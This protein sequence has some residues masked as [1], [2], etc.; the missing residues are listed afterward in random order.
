MHKDWLRASGHYFRL[1]VLKTSSASS[2]SQSHVGNPWLICLATQLFKK[3]L[4][5]LI[6]ASLVSSNVWA[7]DLMDIYHQALDNDPT[8]KAAYAN[9]LAQSEILP[10]A[11]STLLP[12]LSFA[13]LAGRNNQFINAGTY[14]VNQTYNGN[15]WTVDAS[16]A[17]FNYQAWEKV[18]QAESSV[19]A[20][21]ATFNDA[22]Q[23]LIIRTASAY[24]QVLLAQ[25]TLNFAEAKK[26]A[27]KRQLD[28]AQERFNVGLEPI[29]AVY[30]ARAAYD[31][32]IS[33]VISN[34][35]NLTNLNQNL[36][37]ITN[38]VYEH[39]AP[40]RDQRIPLIGPE[41]N[42][43]DEWISAGLKQNYNL[44]AARYNLQSA[45]DNI[46]ANS[47]GNW[48]IFSIQGHVNDVHLASSE[49][50]SGKSNPANATNL[51]NN[52]FI[53]QE[54][55][56]ANLT[57]NVNMPIFQG[58]LVASK[59]RQAEYNFQSSAQKFEQVYRDVVVNSNIYFNT[60]VD[61]I[62]KVRADRQ[63]I[64]S[65]QNSLDSVWAQYK[66]G[67]RTMTDVVLAQQ[68][69]FEA[70]RQQAS[71][72]YDLINAI[73]NLKYYAGSLNVSDLEEINTWLDTLRI[74]SLADNKEHAPCKL[75]A[76]QKLLRKMQ[77]LAIPTTS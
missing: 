30:E 63:T 23:S 77:N 6:C 32:S 34:Q 20:A 17:V 25:D 24:L 9:F 68:H 14:V 42:V 61:G 37:R 11:W 55:R 47:A 44:F 22:A 13:A 36:S 15:Q 38:H 35:N 18:Q 52:F 2:N 53:P 64:I 49:Y 50:A 21:L 62:A 29:T 39:I 28:Q 5:S 48:P 27:N 70:Q 69:L 4:L 8:F 19:K 59:T 65:Q 54:Q 58:G 46:K 10:Q 40:L 26:R 56:I 51:V 41:P 3:P 66:V 7:A 60:I 16:Q 45:R 75:S 72:Q 67:T 33:E 76:T 73:L 1:A 43:V 57:I 31:Q 12:Q 74:N 71:D